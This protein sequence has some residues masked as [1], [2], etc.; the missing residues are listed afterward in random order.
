MNILVT[1]GAG[2][3]GTNF[4]DLLEHKSCNILNIDIVRPKNILHDKYFMKVD[5]KDFDA[6]LKAF[7]NFDPD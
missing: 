1:G 5:I 2:F 3:I 7:Q 6:L 4:I